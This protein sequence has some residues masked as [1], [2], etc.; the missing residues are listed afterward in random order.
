[1]HQPLAEVG[2]WLKSVVQDYFNYHAVPGNIVSS[3]SSAYAD[4]C[5]QPEREVHGEYEDDEEAAP[6]G[7]DGS[8]RIVPGAPQ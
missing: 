5:T 7:P 2:K 4:L 1:M 3:I 8:S 6:T